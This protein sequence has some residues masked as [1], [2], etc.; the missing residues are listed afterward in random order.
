MKHKNNVGTHPA[1]DVSKSDPAD[2][3]LLPIKYYYASID[4]D[5]EYGDIRKWVSR[6]TLKSR[7]SGLIQTN[8]SVLL[9]S[10][11]DANG[12]PV[13]TT[14]IEDTSNTP[15]GYPGV[16]WGSSALFSTFS[17]V[18]DN[19][20][21]MPEEQGLRCTYKSVH[22]TN[23]V[24]KIQNSGDMQSQFTVGLVSGLENTVKSL[25]LS[26]GSAVW[27]SQAIGYYV[28]FYQV[29]NG[30]VEYLFSGRKF[31]VLK[32]ISDTVIY[33]FDAE[34]D[35]VD[36]D[37]WNG[38]VWGFRKGDVCV[39]QEVDLYFEPIG[40]GQGVYSANSSSEAQ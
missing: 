33:V 31:H 39:I 12:I 17:Q 2:W 27:D 37:S 21:M 30:E 4:T 19:E 29:V 14:N 36:T 38:E 40:R 26:G 32:R 22:L 6:A 34:N 16:N 20:V 24:V 9:K 5:F 11:N 3:S 18:I 35:L 25:T 7:F 13:D 8:L 15:W 28:K 1:V 10:E 23:A